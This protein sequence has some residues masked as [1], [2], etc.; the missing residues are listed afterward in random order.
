MRIILVILGLLLAACGRTDGTTRT[1]FKSPSNASGMVVPDGIQISSSD[2][3]FLPCGYDTNEGQCV[4]VS[5][6]GKKILIGAPTGAAGSLSDQDLMSL[7]LVI[8]ISLRPSDLEGLDSIRNAS[9]LAG[10]KAPLRVAGPEGADIVI[11]ALNDMYEQSDAL[12]YVE[13][14]AAGGFDAALLVPV[15]ADGQI[16]DT[17]DLIVFAE[18]DFDGRVHAAIR[19][20]SWV[21]EIYPCGSEPMV[22][23]SE[24]SFV[25]A[26]EG[27]D[28]NW[29]IHEA[30]FINQ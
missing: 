11:D 13:Q 20:E 18:E 10:R 15:K 1:L 12:A 2:F 3:V 5:A 24:E 9:W 19:Y 16:L 7:D 25:L 27:F 21:T 29:P 22:E 6:G 4:V 28:A 26:C 23:P 8:L 14:G 17:G 30:V